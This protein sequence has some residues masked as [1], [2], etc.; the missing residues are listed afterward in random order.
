MAFNFSNIS[1]SY[2]A[3]G[4]RTRS[5]LPPGSWRFLMSP[6][7]RRSNRSR[8]APQKIL[9]ALVGIALLTAP[10]AANAFKPTLP[11]ADAQASEGCCGMDQEYTFRDYTV[12]VWDEVP[13]F[14]ELNC[15][16]QDDACLLKETDQIL[17]VYLLQE[18]LVKRGALERARHFANGPAMASASSFQ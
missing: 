2:D 18:A 1:R 6:L 14:S 15:P 16:D 7:L 10:M 9:G 11:K 8:T 4:N 12:E 3:A 17:R 13:A 5:L